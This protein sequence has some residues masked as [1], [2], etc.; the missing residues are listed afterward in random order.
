[1]MNKK[2]TWKEL[3]ALDDIY[4]LKKTKAVIQE[5]PYINYLIN[6]KGILDL[7]R[8][9]IKVIISTER[10]EEFY[11]KE[12]KIQYDEAKSFL[13][14]NGIEANAKKNFTL[15]E[16]KTLMLIEENKA[17][18]KSKPTNIED[19]SNEFFDISKYLK[20]KTGLRNAVFKILDINQ[21]PLDK[22]E[23]QWRIVVD[24]Q[25]P[26]AVVLCENKSFLKQTWIAKSTNV[27]LWYVGGNNIKV[28][29][30][31]DEIELVKPFY[32]CCDWDLAGLEIYERIKKK[33]MLRNKD[34]IL[35][36][37]N[38]P[39]KKISTYIEYHDSHWN[40]NKVLSGLQIENFNKKELQLIQDLIKN[41][42]WI[43]EE[44]FDLIQIL[45]LVLQII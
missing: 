12:F 33:L 10:F 8:D 4:H 7:K 34:I 25:N 36:Y 5:H 9:N 26:D 43:E 16:V 38:E 35:L 21:F 20:N 24:R 44:S 42:L 19:F 30:D 17:E 31:I 37:P 14:N 28:L 39:H 13:E 23:N 27:K 45:K 41:E 6:D 22:K 11:E 32:Y 18:L 15:E 1:M 2:I 29:D 40:L 3:K